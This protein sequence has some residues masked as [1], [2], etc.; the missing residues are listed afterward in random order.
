MLPD[1]PVAAAAA[2]GPEGPLALT[3]PGY[4][5][6]PG[7]LEMASA[8]AE[9]LREDRILLVEAGTG[10][11]KTLAYLVP[12][13]QS[14]RKVVISTATRA[15]QEQIV[16]SDLPL[17]ARALGIEP[18]IAVMKG[19]GNYLCRRR[20]ADFIAS[21]E[22]LAPRHARGL[23]VID[24][25]LAQTASGDVGELTELPEDEPLLGHVTASS[26]TRLG[27]ACPHHESCFVT[28][29]RRAAERAQ[30]VVVNHHL[31][32]AD[33]A[34]RGPHPGR[35]IPD[36][37][38]VIFD[39][40]HQ[41]EEVAT[42]FFGMRVS[43][44]RLSL[45]GH[46]ATRALERARAVEPGLVPRASL[47]LPGDLGTAVT[48]FFAALGEALG[49]GEGRIAVERDAWQG[50]LGS[51]WLG[52]DSALEGVGALA[53]SVAARL[54]DPGGRP[55]GAG[56][57]TADALEVVARRAE[58]V[59]D[60]L[61]AIADAARGLVTWFEPDPTQPAISAAPVA[62]ASVF[63]ARLFER[64]PAVV[65]TSATLTT[66]SHAAEGEA[67]APDDARSPSEAPPPRGDF[68]YLRA[69]LGLDEAGLAV[70][71][72]VVASP[73]DFSAS[74][75]LYLPR[76]LPPPG[77]AGFVPA[78]TERVAELIDLTGGGAFVLTTSLRSMRALARGLRARSPQRRVLLQ[79]EAP[80]SALI[81]DFRAAGDAVLVATMGF[82]EGVDVPGRALR[83]VVLEKVPFAVPTDP[84]VRAR[85]LA[86]EEEGKNPFVDLFVPAAA[87]TLKQG[88]GRL[89]RT[90][91]DRG[92][93]ALLDG[94]VTSRG[95]GRRL[96]DALPPARRTADLE[97]V[98][99]FAATELGGDGHG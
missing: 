99:A 79:G 12:V 26:D 41:L 32:F 42:S 37:E 40:A 6:R 29:M 87:I 2:L 96:L 97:V 88:F 38:A 9:A 65:L 43:R 60:H 75:L 72:R 20:H 17:A 21:A 52:L 51:R 31:F 78:A 64:V 85:A 76:D 28:R 55:G 1:D 66:G 91:R 35:V 25:W 89:V 94:R 33:L 56:S 19:L 67:A 81:A 36:Y 4:E 68:T 61:A 46:D 44:S 45:L 23:R 71:E 62:V 10:T 7:Q 27:P 84:V 73:F 14:G 74:V 8:V 3:L 15:L 30:V 83:L 69:R 22:A 93:V 98:R 63:R 24:R 86:L 34:L 70:D 53:G 59:R 47:G 48:D 18:A 95:Y 5:V 39:E 57:A 13:L 49:A 92:V 54:R 80:K 77:E 82:W 90:R 50:D 16:E 58:L 11:G